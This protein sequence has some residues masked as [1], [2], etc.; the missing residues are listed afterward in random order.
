MV[1]YLGLR[2]RDICVLGCPINN[3][4]EVNSVIIFAILFE[5][6]CHILTR[7]RLMSLLRLG[8]GDS[9]ITSC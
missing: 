2:A 8:R 7:E 5:N 9:V 6:L 4:I 1:S 3:S